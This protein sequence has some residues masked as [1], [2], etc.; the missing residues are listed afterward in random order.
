MSQLSIDTKSASIG[1]P[2]RKLWI[3]KENEN[4]MKM[5]RSARRSSHR[6]AVPPLRLF[7]ARRSSGVGYPSN[8]PKVTELC[9]N[10]YTGASCIARRSRGVG[11][12]SP[13]AQSAARRYVSEQKF[14]SRKN[15]KNFGVF[16][17]NLDST[18]NNSQNKHTKSNT[19]HTR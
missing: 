1:H 11:F 3:F 18:L 8:S 17:P 19:L 6:P 13:G 10:I 15:L 9:I 7:I 4:N 14:C 12:S 16:H 5:P 2:S